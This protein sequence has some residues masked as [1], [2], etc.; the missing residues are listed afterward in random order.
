M[1]AS[2]LEKSKSYIQL[3]ETYIMKYLT[4]EMTKQLAVELAL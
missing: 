1:P 3:H 4:K 2:N